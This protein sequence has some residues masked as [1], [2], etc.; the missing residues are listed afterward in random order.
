MIYIIYSHIAILMAS[1]EI[2]RLA[3]VASPHV[4][5]EP[6][7]LGISALTAP[8]MLPGAHFQKLP[9]VSMHVWLWKKTAQAIQNGAMISPIW[10]TECCFDSRN[11]VEHMLLIWSIWLKWSHT[12]CFIIVFFPKYEIL[13]IIAVPSKKQE[14]E[15]VWSRVHMIFD[16][17]HWWF[18]NHITV[19][20]ETWR[21]RF[22]RA[23]CGSGRWCSS[24]VLG[25]PILVDKQ[26]WGDGSYGT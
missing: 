2:G 7:Q 5:E 23:L 9:A 11:H 13:S 3:V 4:L 14:N 10:C 20:R 21:P 8:W 1:L 25:T 22:Y 16:H 26:N 24:G 17:I 12:C 6:A 15:A 19:P 18:A